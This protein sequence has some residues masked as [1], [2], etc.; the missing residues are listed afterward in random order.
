MG[1]HKESMGATVDEIQLLKEVKRKTREQSGSLFYTALCE[2][3]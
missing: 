2:K 1:I 3:K